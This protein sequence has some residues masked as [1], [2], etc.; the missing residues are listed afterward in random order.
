[1]LLRWPP[2]LALAL[3]L[4]ACGGGAAESTGVASPESAP[5]RASP[6]ESADTLPPDGP[7]PGGS[8]RGDTRT[9]EAIGQ[10]VKAN[11]KEARAC[12]EHAL[13]QRNDLRGN[14]VI[15]F[16]LTPSGKVKT[17][18]VN[19]E[20]STLSDPGVAACVIEVIRGLDFPASSR[21]RETTV[22]YPFNFNP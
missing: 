12:Y 11:R 13:K 3:T 14:L 15:H 9:T 22:N 6:R 7:A 1:M 16:T 20:R 4:S 21:G 2:V 8:G 5:S 17:A 19:Q 10:V 18:G